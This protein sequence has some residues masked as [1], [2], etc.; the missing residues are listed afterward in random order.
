[1]S[2][3]LR[4]FIALLLIVS[5]FPFPAAAQGKKMEDRTEVVIAFPKEFPPHCF[6][7]KK[8]QP[9]GFAIDAMNQ[10]A[11]LAGL[12]VT[13]KA[14]QNFASAQ[15]SLRDGQADLIPNSGITDERLLEFDFTTPVETFD[16][17]IFIRKTTHDINS[18]DDL[19]GRKVAVI[20]TNVGEIMVNERESIKGVVY[21]NISAA[22][23]DLLAGKVDAFIYPKSVGLYLAGEAGIVDLIK[24][25]G[26]PLIEIK[27]GIR[28]RKGDKLL[29]K[30]NP[31]VEQFLRSEEY[32]E[33]YTKWYGKPQT[34]WTPVKV[35]IVMSSLTLILFI[36]MFTWRYLSLNRIN[37]ELTQSIVERAQI[38][39]ELR[40]ANKVLTGLDKMKSM[41]IASMSHELRTPLNSILGFT[42]I[43][44]DG[45]PGELNPKQ[46]DQLG[47]AHRSARHLLAMISDVIDIS[48]IESA[49]LT[50][51][52][53][54][55]ILEE[56]VNEAIETIKPQAEKK[57][58]V[59]D[60]S[61]PTDIKMYTD[62]RRLF[63][64]SLNL[65]TNALKFTESGT[66]TVVA[67]E[68]NGTVHISISDTGIGISKEDLPKI[69]DAF[70]RLKSHLQ[71]KAG[72]VGLGLYLTKKL[73]TEVLKGTIEVESEKGKGSTFRLKIPKDLEHAGL[74]K[75]SGTREV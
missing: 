43:V 65:L 8:G 66:I 17:V 11:G 68:S 32:K 14:E 4:I 72:G 27:R 52:P 18:F 55:F 48:M 40:K 47:R 63:Q 64:C 20:I 21:H 70:E 1:M 2:F 73:A 13:Y 33:I 5:F 38:T 49:R 44:L 7:D 9:T 26:K 57:G 42:G 61:T 34:F 54:E 58:L 19:D 6:L 45:M 75:S 30:L 23:F 59:F 35:V 53:E 41:F 12:K 22:L 24:I 62:R 31:A 39:D 3:F 56:L 50:V 10:I 74:I 15:E 46:R 28:L 36:S 51:S 29:A 71:V 60:V 16:V 37:K 25:A 69:F 67:K